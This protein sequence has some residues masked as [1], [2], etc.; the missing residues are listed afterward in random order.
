MIGTQ[1]IASVCS[2][3]VLKL[4][5]HEGILKSSASRSYNTEEYANTLSFGCRTLPSLLSTRP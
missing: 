3:D 5:T 4:R 2:V 1:R